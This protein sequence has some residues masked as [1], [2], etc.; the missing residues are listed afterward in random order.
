MNEY[1]NLFRKL[2]RNTYIS[3]PLE[4]LRYKLRF[5]KVQSVYWL[6]ITWMADE[7]GIYA[8]RSEDIPLLY[9]AQTAQTASLLIDT[10][11][12]IVHSRRIGEDSAMWQRDASLCVPV[13]L[14]PCLSSCFI[15]VF[16]FS[17][18][19]ATVSL[20]VS[21]CLLCLCRQVNWQSNVSRRGLPDLASKWQIPVGHSQKCRFFQEGRSEAN[22]SV[23]P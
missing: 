18:F 22:S 14:S 1:T 17:V 12:L 3:L 6:L 13:S 10:Y 16:L 11:F 23:R 7:S 8:A 21:F 19:L 15:H 4:W 9:S 2:S 5:T 20:F